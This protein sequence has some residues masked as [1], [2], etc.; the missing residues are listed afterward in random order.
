MGNKTWG[1][2]VWCFLHT[3]SFKIKEENFDEQRV[4]ILNL[5]KLIFAN[6]SCPFCSKDASEL[7][8]KTNLK[9]II[10]K[11]SLIDFLYNFH[12]KINLKLKKPLFKKS[13]L[14]EKYNNNKFS[15]VIKDFIDLYNKKS[16]NLRISMLYKN[17]KTVIKSVIDHFEQYQQYYD[18]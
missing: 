5:I 18:N 3:L 10:N 13:E 15:E 8:Q 12:N 7:Y 2:I 1:P 6:L 4:K 11:A 14:F 16:S 17:N 9:Y